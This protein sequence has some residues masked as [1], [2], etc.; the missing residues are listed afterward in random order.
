MTVALKQVNENN[1][2][3]QAVEHVQA[4]ISSQY[5]DE[6]VSIIK[7]EIQELCTQTSLLLDCSEEDVHDQLEID[8]KLGGKVVARLGEL[9]AAMSFARLKVVSNLTVSLG[10]ALQ[11]VISS[12]SQVDGSQRAAI[13]TITYL[14]NRYVDLCVERPKADTGLI[15]GPSFYKLAKARLSKHCVEADL[16]ETDF[17]AADVLVNAGEISSADLGLDTEDLR[18]SRQMFQVAL[19]ALLRGDLGVE[20][21][22]I[23]QRVC[24][25]NMRA[26]NEAYKAVW[27][28]L[29][30]LINLFKSNSLALSQQRCYVLS[31]FD[32]LL[33]SVLKAEA[34]NFTQGDFAKIPA[35][36]A[37]LIT[38]GT[39]DEIQLDK[40]LGAF[41]EPVALSETSLQEQ[42]KKLE[43]GVA[44][45]LRA[46]C[47]VCQERLSHARTKLEGITTEPEN[48]KD[49]IEEVSSSLAMVLSVLEFNDLRHLSD[50]LNESVALF[51]EWIG[52]G[53]S[54]DFTNM[55]PSLLTVENAAGWLSRQVS[56]EFSDQNADQPL[57]QEAQLQLCDEIQ[58][59]LG[60]ATRA[61]TSYTES[62][63]DSKHIA[64]LDQSLVGAAKGFEMLEKNSLKELILICAESISQR[65]ENEIKELD[66][67]IELVADSLVT[68]DGLINEIKKSRKPN[69]LFEK[70]IQ[71]NIEL[72]KQQ[73]AN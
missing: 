9:A 59:N 8:A 39:E 55:A 63:F 6:A 34:I 15:V 68:A 38:L 11:N 71:E 14:L 72:F 73:M 24:E 66:P 61:L 16:L 37:L 53:Y 25:H 58:A 22:N 41:S 60:L 45:S 36:L 12:G 43:S 49:A 69:A 67:A 44:E 13:F 70:I 65:L 52:S 4:P 51:R 54:T 50:K 28:Q 47:N 46:V 40:T 33:R 31:Y 5:I 18:R 30:N 42:R 35:E 57:L 1:K 3:V 19:I 62:G 56:F 21:L 10:N 2:R 64:N 7:D 27:S 26:E 23:M 17:L 32:R 48:H 20:P 29:S